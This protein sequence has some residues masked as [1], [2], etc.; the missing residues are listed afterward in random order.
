MKKNM[1]I[2]EEFPINSKDSKIFF[3]HKDRKLREFGHDFPKTAPNLKK[4]AERK[5]ERKETRWRTIIAIATNK[6]K[7]WLNEKHD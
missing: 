6:K 2:T 3:I 5:K 1:K 4:L 7:D